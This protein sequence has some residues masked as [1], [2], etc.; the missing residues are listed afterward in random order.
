MGLENEQESE[1][2]KKYESTPGKD[3][4]GKDIA[5]LE[6]SLNLASPR[7]LDTT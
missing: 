2:K 3:L 4:L 5:D 1:F 6:Q 7:I